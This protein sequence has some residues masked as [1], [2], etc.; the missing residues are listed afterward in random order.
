MIRPLLESDDPSGFSCG[1]HE[2][3]AYLRRHALDNAA[4]GAGVTWVLEDRELGI[5]GYVTLAAASVRSNELAS[6]PHAA[7]GLP[8]YPLPALLV[9]RLAVDERLRRRGLGRALLTFAFDEALIARDR[10]GCIGVLVD[11]KP[12]AVGFYERF[13]FGEVRRAGADS[14]VGRMFLGIG[15]LTDALHRP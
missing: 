2:L 6:D 5:G 11:A 3:D 14:G 12:P 4:A 9:A 13:G 10:I 1:V 7:A 15:T 8:R